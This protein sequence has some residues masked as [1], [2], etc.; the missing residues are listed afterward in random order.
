[1][2]VVVAL[3]DADTA[4]ERAVQALRD[5]RLIVLPT[6]SVYALAA[7]AFSRVATQRLFGAKRR[8]RTTPLTVLI[9]SQRQ[10]TGLVEH[11]SEPAERLMAAYW[12]GPLTLVFPAVPELSWDIGQTNGTVSL[13]LP[14]DDLLLDLVADVGPLAVTAANRLGEPVPTDVSS[15]RRQ[16]GLSAAVY[17][18]GGERTGPSSTVVDVTGERAVVLRAGAIPAEDV[19]Q[20]A[21]GR[22]GWG[23]R[24]AAEG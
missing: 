6:D 14:A 13:R 5:D 7:N 4:R 19:E 16:L 21:E 20:V 24:P 23:A 2:S 1:M 8:G 22:T 9:R 18:D 12:P 11:I 15:A 17:L 10:T 3:T